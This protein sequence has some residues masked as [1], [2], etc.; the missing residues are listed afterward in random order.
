VSERVR[1]RCAQEGNAKTHIVRAWCAL[2]LLA[3]GAGAD[4]QT[5]PNRPIRQIVPFASGS[6]ADALARVV[7]D[8][9][10]Q[11]LGQPVIIDSR[12]GANS[13]IAPRR[14]QGAGRRLYVRPAQRRCGRAQHGALPKLPYRRCKT[15]PRSPAPAASPW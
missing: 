5:Y 9:L 8:K 2:V 3:C 6:A 14:P 11:I 7:G 10:A 13:M 1:R 12:P 4:A 15:S